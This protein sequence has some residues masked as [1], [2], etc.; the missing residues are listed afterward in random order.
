MSE[1]KR[2]CMR[3]TE[4]GGN[5]QAIVKIARDWNK[6]DGQFMIRPQDVE[7]FVADLPVDKL[8]VK[9]R[10]AD[11]R[12]TTAECVSSVLDPAL[13]DKLLDTAYQRGRRPVRLPGVGVRLN[14]EESLH[15]LGLF[16]EAGD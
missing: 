3:V 10:F 7:T 9:I 15:Q 1:V 12:R 16:G 2:N 8:F 14:E 4:C 13:C 5:L 11:F 6:P